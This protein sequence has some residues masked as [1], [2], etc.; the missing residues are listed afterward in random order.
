MKRTVI[1][2]PVTCA[3]GIWLGGAAALAAAADPA[4]TAMAAPSAE[5]ASVAGVTPAEL[6]ARV[7]RQ[8]K[9]LVVL[10][11]RSAEEF[12]AG[13]VPGARNVA[14]DQLHTRL[15]ELAADKD[16]DVVLYCR[17]GRRALHAAQILR[18]AGFTRLLHL[19]GDYPAWEA[20]LE[21]EPAPATT[22]KD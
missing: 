12:A 4:P 1:K 16:K 11:V 22:T 18:D 14:H 10:D 8:D 7:E 6:A 9:D 13:H 3:L 17:S 15:Q 2:L 20:S 21:G 19:E 5:Q